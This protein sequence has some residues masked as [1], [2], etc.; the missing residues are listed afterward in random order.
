MPTP[1]LPLSG[2]IDMG[3][4]QAAFPGLGDPPNILQFIGQH[5]LLPANGGPYGMDMFYGLTA[6]SPTFSFDTTMLTNGS[7]SPLSST[8]IVF[9]SPGVSS[10]IL[11]SGSVD[12]A[13]FVQNKSYQ[14]TLT[15]ALAGTLPI[16]ASLSSS[17]IITL[18]CGTP[19]TSSLTVT[20][21]NKWG[22]TNIV[23]IDFSF[24]S[25]LSPQPSSSVS[26]LTYG[27]YTNSKFS[28]T[29]VF[30]VQNTTSVDVTSF[31][32]FSVAPSG[33]LSNGA[34][35]LSGLC[36]PSTIPTVTFTLTN[37]VIGL[38]ASTAI[39]SYTGSSSPSVPTAPEPGSSLTSLVYGSLD[40]INGQTFYPMYLSTWTF[41]ITN[42]TSVALNG[43]SNFVYDP[44]GS[45]NNGVF[46]VT[47][48]V[49]PSTTTTLSLALTNAPTGYNTSSKTVSY[50]SPT[51]GVAVDV[52]PAVVDN[53]NI[54]FNAFD[55]YQQ[56]WSFFWSI[57][58]KNATVATLISSNNT[59]TFTLAGDYII[60]NGR[61]FPGNIPNAQF[62]LYNPV[63]GFMSVNATSTSTAPPAPPPPATAIGTPPYADFGIKT[64]Q[65]GTTYYSNASYN[66]A[67]YFQNCI[68]FAITGGT[69]SSVFLYSGN[70][71]QAYSTNPPRSPI[72]ANGNSY[73]PQYTSFIITGTDAAGG[74]ATQTFEI[75]DYGGLDG[76]QGN[77]QYF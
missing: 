55:H 20:V 33:S 23:T 69:A 24:P 29:W 1:I 74:T 72:D 25:A 65:G 67:N 9:N 44:S 56:Q 70:S 37:N 13:T 35:T 42:A 40:Y 3:L 34:Y 11:V 17:G 16:G 54:S 59:I 68:S 61:C 49:A 46:T 19:V 66:L 47:G 8:N 32:G 27:T 26:S 10:T 58:V 28:V 75:H 53:G 57:H 5:P 31:T 64:F 38:V 71:I 12:L 41:A 6:V 52:N 14:G 62:N 7:M 51:Q 43:F 48:R 30:N 60:V 39:A 63:T 18:A 15:F 77:T 45:F 36:A 2:Q 4:I 21:T 73:N 50:T 76:Q 22:N